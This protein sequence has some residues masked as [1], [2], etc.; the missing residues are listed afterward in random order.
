M[1][2]HGLPMAINAEEIK[3]SSVKQCSKRKPVIIIVTEQRFPITIKVQKVAVLI[4]LLWVEHS[5]T[6]HMLYIFVYH[7]ELM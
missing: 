4:D 6:W 2:I 1:R 3:S 7:Q 5:Q